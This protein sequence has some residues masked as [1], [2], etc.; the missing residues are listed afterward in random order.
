MKKI[1]ILANF[2]LILTSFQILAKEIQAKGDVSFE[3]GVFSNEP[4]IE[5]K[6]KAIDA[7][8]Q[9]AWKKYTSEFSHAKLNSYKQTQSYFE[10]HLDEFVIEKKVLDQVL[11]SNTNTYSVVT[12]VNFNDVA[13]DSKLNEGN[14]KAVLGAGAVGAKSLFSFLFL[15]REQSAVKSFDA[16]KTV[17]AK[18]EENELRSENTNINAS[19]TGGEK[20]EARTQDVTL[21]TGGSTLKKAN[22]TEYRV[23]SSGDIDEGVL[24]F[25]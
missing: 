2:I 19:G 1:V 10:T 22:E 24:D 6:Q 17:K 5:T 16:R 21:T 12:K 11:D 18:K 9:N 20:Q 14:S 15:A 3:S 7:A 8:I 23:Y 13:I 4:D 25:V